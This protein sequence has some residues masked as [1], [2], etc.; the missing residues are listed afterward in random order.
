MTRQ[1]TSVDRVLRS[2]MVG[3]LTMEIASSDLRKSVLCPA[4]SSYRK[5]GRFSLAEK[6]LRNSHQTL[7]PDLSIPLEARLKF[8]DY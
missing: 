5:H 2:D 4:I 7:N 8:A 6:T 3:A 1:Y